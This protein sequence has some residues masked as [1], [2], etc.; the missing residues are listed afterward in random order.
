MNATSRTR[1]TRTLN[2]RLLIT[3]IVTGLGLVLLLV[4]GVWAATHP[5]Y[6]ADTPVLTSG[7]A[8]IADIPPGHWYDA[9]AQ[10]SAGT[11]SQVISDAG[12]ATIGVAGCLLGVLCCLI[13]FALIR[14]FALR[15]PP[16]VVAVL[17]RIRLP[18]VITDRSST[19]ALSLSQLSLSRT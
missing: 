17:R 3:R 13:V 10:D 9:T 11:T 5:A 1:S 2:E 19:P 6:D 15:S 7:A 14:L 4:I 16:G 18:Q 12:W 8:R